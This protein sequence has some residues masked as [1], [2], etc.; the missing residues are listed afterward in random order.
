MA[1]NSNSCAGGAP[2]A[3][4]AVNEDR[5]GVESDEISMSIYFFCAEKALNS[6]S[7]VYMG[8]ADHI[9]FLEHCSVSAFPNVCLWV[10]SGTI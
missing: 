9:K 8:Q 4:I 7:I 2:A 6:L 3:V 1:G 10:L 5:E